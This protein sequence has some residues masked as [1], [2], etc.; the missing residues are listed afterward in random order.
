MAVSES[1]DSHRRKQVIAR[2]VK[3]WS[4]RLFSF[5]RRRVSSDEDAE[6]AEID[7]AHDGQAS[8]TSSA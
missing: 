3:D 2:V 6:D 4:G 1:P 5:I 7:A 8:D